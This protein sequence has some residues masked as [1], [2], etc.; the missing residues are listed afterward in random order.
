MEVWRE[1]STIDSRPMA[2]GLIPG[3]MGVFIR[4]PPSFMRSS[5][6]SKCAVLRRGGQAVGPVCRESYTLSALK[7]PCNGFITSKNY[8]GIQGCS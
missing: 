1:V 8:L 2:P 4:P 3:H 7:S 6:C 5:D